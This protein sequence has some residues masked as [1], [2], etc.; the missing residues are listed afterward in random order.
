MGSKL[1]CIFQKL[2]VAF[3]ILISPL[4]RCLLHLRGLAPFARS[5]TIP[6]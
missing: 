3:T 2:V 5:T 4:T 6:T 1:I